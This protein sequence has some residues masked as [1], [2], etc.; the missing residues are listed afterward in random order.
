MSGLNDADR[1]AVDQAPALMLAEWWCLLNNWEW[2]RE[3]LGE[4][5]PVPEKHRPDTRRGQIMDAIA[6]R[7]G[8]KECL[9]EWNRERMQPAEFE[10]WWLRYHGH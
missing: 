3:G 5:D 7:I 4:P 10:A 9:R 1:A 2:P 8:H 6:E